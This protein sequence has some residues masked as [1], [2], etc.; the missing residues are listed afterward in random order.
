[1]QLKIDNTYQKK[2]HIFFLTD[3]S[4]HLILSVCRFKTTQHT[5]KA[6]AINEEDKQLSFASFEWPS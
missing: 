1:M 2:Q 3:S 4:L 6:K 5:V